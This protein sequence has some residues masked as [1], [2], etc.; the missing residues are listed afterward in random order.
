MLNVVTGKSSTLG[1]KLPNAAAS[2]ELDACDLSHSNCIFLQSIFI[3]SIYECSW[4]S[5]I[6]HETTLL[7]FYLIFLIGGGSCEIT[8][9][10]V[11][12]CRGAK[13]NDVNRCLN[14]YIF[15]LKG[16][17]FFLLS[18]LK[19]YRS[20]LCPIYGLYISICF[21]HLSILQ[22]RMMIIIQIPMAVLQ[23]CYVSDAEAILS[24]KNLGIIALLYIM[25]MYTE[26]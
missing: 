16:R 8:L 24:E 4:Y 22:A 19:R 18:F 6:A 13:T 23:F 17:T 5:I 12:A 3:P 20:D 10:I 14:L 7:M 21:V 26:F 25:S 11:G 15:L 2:F 1:S 9:H